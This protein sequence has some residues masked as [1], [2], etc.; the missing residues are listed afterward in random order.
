MYVIK[1]G[2]TEVALL[3]PL[4]E[5][6]ELEYVRFDDNP[7]VCD[8]EVSLGPFLVVGLDDLAETVR[9]IRVGMNRAEPSLDEDSSVYELLDD[10]CGRAI[11]LLC[12]LEGEARSDD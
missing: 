9:I 7:A 2:A 12:S 3:M 1:S 6:F 4:A 10:W 8:P 11:E 5:D